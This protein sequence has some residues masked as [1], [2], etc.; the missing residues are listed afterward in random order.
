MRHY[1]FVILLFLIGCVSVGSTIPVD[2]QF[3]DLPGERR[4]ELK[5][6]NSTNATLCLLPEAWPN[7]G[8]MIYEGSAHVF[9]IIGGR[10][11][12]IAESMLGYC[13]PPTDCAV[14]VSPGE[15]VAASIPYQNFSAPDDLVNFRKTL[16]FSTFAV[17][18]R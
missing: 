16:E 11:F 8:G 3:V 6:R 5:F 9:L 4:I 13:D 12:P 7:S 2:Y 17:R 1:Y 10:R 18:C 15:E 14:R